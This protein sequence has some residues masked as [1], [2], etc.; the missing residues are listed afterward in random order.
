MGFFSA[1]TVTIQV[2]VQFNT[3][4]FKTKYL[5]KSVNQVSN[6]ANIS[7]QSFL[8]RKDLQKVKC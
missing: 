5:Q 8:D 7:F 3:K 6:R 1:H 2:L 4:Y